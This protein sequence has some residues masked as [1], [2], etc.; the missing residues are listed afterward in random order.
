MGPKSIYTLTCEDPT[1]PLP[2][3]ALGCIRFRQILVVIKATIIW[4]NECK[5][6]KSPHKEI[7]I[8]VCECAT[9]RVC[10]VEQ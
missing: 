10:A 1:C 2:L 3:L 4:K 8:S 9:L 6:L 5:S 7:K